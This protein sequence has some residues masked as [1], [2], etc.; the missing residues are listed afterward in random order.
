VAKEMFLNG[1]PVIVLSI[2]EVKSI[3]KE[4]D[5]ALS[6]VDQAIKGFKE[7]QNQVSDLLVQLEESMNQT[8]AALKICADLENQLEEVINLKNEQSKGIVRII[9]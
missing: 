9:N 8:R 1:I 5:E 4:R 3:I 6:M 2:G 7:A